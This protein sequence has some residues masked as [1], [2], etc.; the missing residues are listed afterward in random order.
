[1]LEQIENIAQPSGQPHPLVEKPDDVGGNGDLGSHLC[2][3]FL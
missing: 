3:G 1:M 2:L